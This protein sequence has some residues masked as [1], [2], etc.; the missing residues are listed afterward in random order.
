MISHNAILLEEERALQELQAHI[1]K[2][3]QVYGVESEHYFSDFPE[4]VV[5]GYLVKNNC[6]RVEA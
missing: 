4:A 5:N 6:V 2:S 3:L 1:G